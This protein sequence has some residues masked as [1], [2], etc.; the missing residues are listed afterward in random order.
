VF[1]FDGLSGSKLTPRNAL[2]SLDESKFPGSQAS[3]KMGADLGMSDH[4]HTS[5]QSVADQGAF[6][7]NRLA[8]EVL[9]TGERERFPNS[10]KRTDGFLLKL[11]PF[12]RCTDHS[13]GLVSK[14]GCQLPMRGHHFSWRMDLFTVARRVGCDFSRLFSRASRAFKVFTCFLGRDRTSIAIRSSSIG[15]RE[16]G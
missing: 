3:V 2:L 14:I 10:L 5:A 16:H 1:G 13:L 7:Y 4:A 11:R 12:P 6:V 9:I 8:L 15:A